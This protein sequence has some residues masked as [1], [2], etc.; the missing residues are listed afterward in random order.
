MASRRDNQKAA[1]HSATSKPFSGSLHHIVE[2]LSDGILVVDLQKRIAFVNGRLAQDYGMQPEE[3]IGQ[4]CQ[5]LIGFDHCHSC[6]HAGIVSGGDGYTGHNLTC[7]RLEN[8]PFC[9][10]ATPYEDEQ[11]NI[12]GMVETF[13]DMRALGAYIEGIESEKAALDFERQRLNHILSDSSDGYYTASADRTILEADDKLLDLLGKTRTEVVG[14]PCSAVFGSDKC[15]TDCPIVWAKQ[16]KK[17]VIDCSE[18][19]HTAQGGMPVHKSIFP[20]LEPDGSLGHVIGVIHNA[21]EIVELRSAARNVGGFHGLV[22]LNRQMEEV[23]DLIRTFGPT[24]SSVLVHGES[25]TGKELVARAL[26]DV[27][28]RQHKPFRK[29]NCSALAE[30][31]LESELFGHVRGAFTGAMN[32]K[33]GL[34]EVADGGT[35]FLDEVGDMSP[36]LQTKILRVL[37]E[38]EFERVGGHDTI[39]VNVRVIAATNRDLQ[40]AIRD[41]LFREDLYYRLNAIQIHLPALRERRDDMPLL[42]Q[43]FLSELNRTQDRRVE[44]ISA[45]ALELLQQYDWPGNIRELRN[46]IEFAYVCARSDRIER[47]DLPQHI[48][49]DD[50]SKPDSDGGRSAN[51][52]PELRSAM[53]QYNGDRARVARALGISRT[54][55]WRRLKQLQN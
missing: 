45:R 54:T 15:E 12:V 2:S 21:S 47:A 50:A 33:P 49:D 3:M 44:R 9:V 19:I 37:E 31:I 7:D 17:N 36:N 22:S 38:Q 18:Q 52:D 41:K 53:R 23:F 24:D 35:L 42:V 27:S 8:R 43:H 25:G 30:G 32:D 51:G 20:H 13:R 29:I 28:T 46:A 5:E 34:F 40:K 4:S 39:R 16:H 11:G 1:S 55:L 6:P 10:S 26:Q 48:R 14:R